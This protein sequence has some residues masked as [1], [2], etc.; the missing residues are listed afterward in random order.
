MKI[1][2]FLIGLICIFTTCAF[3]GASTGLGVLLTIK[4]GDYFMY[5][6]I[7]M[8]RQIVCFA[9][10]PTLD[11]R[12]ELQTPNSYTPVNRGIPPGYY[13]IMGVRRFSIQSST[14]VSNGAFTISNWGNPDN[15][16]KSPIMTILCNY[17]AP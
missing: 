6:N 11:I 17:Q 2:N 13:Q 14:Y 16:N 5:E 15:P 4:K 3:A 7:N 1:R 9:K 12:M 8:M 10:A